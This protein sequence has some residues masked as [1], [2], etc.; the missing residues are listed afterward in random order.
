MMAQLD[1]GSHT[2]RGPSPL[3]APSRRALRRPQ[4]IT[5]FN[6]TG[7]CA[8]PP[9]DTSH[10]TTTA[11]ASQLW[12]A[13]EK[14]YEDTRGTACCVLCTVIRKHDQIVGKL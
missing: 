2:P 4:R 5:G 1:P 3:A 8:A 14:A 10:R 6:D 9:S 7:G 12:F 13:W 11:E